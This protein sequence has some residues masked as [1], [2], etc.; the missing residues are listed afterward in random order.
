VRKHKAPRSVRRLPGVVTE[1][2]TAGRV[3]GLAH[4]PCASLLDPASSVRYAHS[5]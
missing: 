4:T 3:Q 1:T 2:V 5:F